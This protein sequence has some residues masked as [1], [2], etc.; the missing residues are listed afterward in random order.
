MGDARE[1]VVGV[2]VEVL[3]EEL[4]ELLV[5]TLYMREPRLVQQTQT[6]LQLTVELRV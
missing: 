6:F 5:L 1:D 2:D 3:L 4:Q